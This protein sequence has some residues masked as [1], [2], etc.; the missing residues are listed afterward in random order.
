M[1]KTMKIAD[2]RGNYLVDHLVGAFHYEALGG[3]HLV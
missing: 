3:L 2:L 1:T